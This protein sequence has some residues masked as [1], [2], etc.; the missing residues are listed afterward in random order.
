M[1]GVLL[2]EVVQKVASAGMS[3]WDAVGKYQSLIGAGLG[4]LINVFAALFIARK[5]AERGRLNFSL[6]QIKIE[7]LWADVILEGKKVGTTTTKDYGVADHGRIMIS[8]DL[9]NSSGVHRVMRDTQIGLRVGRKIRHFEFTEGQIFVLWNGE[10]VRQLSVEPNGLSHIAFKLD[11]TRNRLTQI[12]DGNSPLVFSYKD[13]KD[14]Q[15]HVAIGPL[16]GNKYAW[17][18]YKA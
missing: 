4:A 8:Y 17:F 5:V 9:Y 13:E 10:F 7:A 6:T 2:S 15:R 1:H 14:K 18:D 11:L 3:V 16:I 12:K